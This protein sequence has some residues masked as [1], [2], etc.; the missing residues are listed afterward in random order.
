YSV[1]RMNASVG[2]EPEEVRA[3]RITANLFATLQEAPAVGR[4]FVP[5]ENLPGGPRVAILSDRFWRRRF[6]GLPSAIGATLMLDAEPYEIVGI[7]PNGF[8]LPVDI[9]DNV[10][11]DVYLPLTLP[12]HSA[13]NR[14]L[15]YITA[16]ARLQPDAKPSQAR[17]EAEGISRQFQRDFPNN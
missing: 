4:A 3:A 14:N 7:L 17:S 5:D 2:V 6:G 15:R 13:S 9:R 1:N 8:E 10:R 12:P 11:T 16:I